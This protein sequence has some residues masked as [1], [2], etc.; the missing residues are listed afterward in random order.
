MCTR[1]VC[2]LRCQL[3]FYWS[4][5]GRC[6]ANVGCSW[7][8]SGVGLLSIPYALSEGGWLSLALLLVVAAACCYTGLLLQRCMDASPAVRGYPD[9]GA[10]AFGRGGRLAASAFL[11]AELYL[12]AIGFLILEGD[13]LDKLFPGTSISLGLGTER[14]RRWKQ[15][16]RGTKHGVGATR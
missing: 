10:L 12:V 5:T 3:R 16:R 8:L 4:Y 15:P 14:W 1:R 9:I 6:H 11:Y 13:N 7:F 2:G